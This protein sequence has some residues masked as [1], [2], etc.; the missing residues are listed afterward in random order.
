MGT[1][2]SWN[3]IG[4]Q[5]SRRERRPRL[6][7]SGTFLFRLWVFPCLVSIGIRLVHLSFG[8]ILPVMQGFFSGLFVSHDQQYNTPH[9]CQRLPRSAAAEAYASSQPSSGGDRYRQPFPGG[10]VGYALVR[11]PDDSDHDKDNAYHRVCFHFASSFC[12][13]ALRPPG[14]G[15]PARMLRRSWFDKLTMTAHDDCSP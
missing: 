8:L 3:L 14:R 10:R 2:E 7:S 13:E 15:F 12:C 11:E 1:V 9:E 6:Q 4:T 5:G